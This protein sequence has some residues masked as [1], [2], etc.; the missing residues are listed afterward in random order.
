MCDVYDFKSAAGFYSNLL[1]FLSFYITNRKKGVPVIIKDIDWKFKY[2]K[3]LADYFTL[4]HHIVQYKKGTP[5]RK[6]YEQGISEEQIH[7]YSDYTHYI[8][9][10]YCLN[11]D[12]KHEL[13]T[14]KKSIQLPSEYASI[15]VR[16]GDKLVWES[17][18]IPCDEYITFLRKQ[19]YTSGNLFIHSDDHQEV[20]KFRRYIEQNQL[21]Y[22]IYSITD[23]RDNG[24][25]IV[26][27]CLKHIL[28]AEYRNKKSVDEMTPQEVRAH[29]I[30]MLIAIEIMKASSLVVTDYQSNV[31]RFLKVYS[32]ANVLSVQ[33]GEPTDY[34][35]PFCTPGC[36]GFN[37]TPR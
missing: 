20:L 9:E 37:E 7:P 17:K 15:F 13:E 36:G 28:T 1:F 6:T 27:K 22:T 14:C 5:V 10:F 4:N 19:G 26:Q 8:S 35:T 23:S 24:G 25:A 18:Y 32:P 29:T 11:S 3:G 31:S 12:V 33:G 16:W 30:R 34:S 2:S 21:P